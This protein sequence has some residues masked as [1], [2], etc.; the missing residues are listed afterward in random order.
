[1]GM[2]PERLASSLAQKIDRLCK[3]DELPKGWTPSELI[4]LI[5]SYA[6]L[7]TAA[8][9][10]NTAKTESAN[11]DDLMQH[12]RRGSYKDMVKRAQQAEAVRKTRK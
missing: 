10:F 8:G 7:L 6:Q 1:M 11:L 2:I 9:A 3:K 5:D 12:G 4:S